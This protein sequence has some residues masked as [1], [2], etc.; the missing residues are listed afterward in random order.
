M[1]RFVLVTTK[2]ILM[3]FK[4]IPI[5]SPHREIFIYKLILCQYVR[6]DFGIGG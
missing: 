1:Q 2:F 3:A 5:T 6:H 4:Y